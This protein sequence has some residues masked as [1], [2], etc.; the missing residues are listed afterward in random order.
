MRQ[1]N[2]TVLVTGASSGIGFACAKA[3]C[4]QGFSV[5]GLS[6]RGTAP[7]GVKGLSADITDSASVKSAVKKISETNGRLDIVVNCAGSGISGAAEFTS[8]E[9]AAFQLD[10]N[11]LGTANVCRESVPLLRQSKGV[12]INIS[13]VAGE[14]PIPFQ[15]WYS[16]SKAA[17]N[18]Y[19]SALAN[20]LRPF[21][22][23]VCALM[24]GDIKT[25]FTSARA[26]NPE[27]DDVYS[28]RISRSVSKME[29]D[30]QNG[31][32]PSDVA[33]KVLRLSKRKKLPPSATVGVGYGI[34]VFAGRLLPRSLVNRVLYALYAG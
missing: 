12:I 9:S 7:D 19:S 29:R 27:G 31:M 4:A 30:E 6:R 32:A 2:K 23:R 5:W 21:G 11:L 17:L 1:E 3:F 14:M 26:K 20:E 10:V 13:S 28:G 18:S 16:A 22:I 15:A 34:L 33:K 24:P 8:C 25:D